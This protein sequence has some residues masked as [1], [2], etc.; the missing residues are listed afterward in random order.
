MIVLLLIGKRAVG[1]TTIAAKLEK[2]CGFKHIEMSI[3]L[4]RMRVEYKM[5]NLR[6]RLFVEYLRKNNKNTLAIENLFNQINHEKKV[7]ITGV[8][9]IEEL[10]F[11]KSNYKIDKLISINLKL[12]IFQR[13]HR[14]II[15]EKRNSIIEFLIEEF[16]TIKWG[17]YKI[18]KNC[19][20]NLKNSSLSDSIKKIKSIILCQ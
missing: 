11:L 13:L 19:D 16:Y 7:V 10:L 2:E 5:E 12:N 6:L 4:K 17:N 15:R 14:A 8:R 20:I 18:S 9:H 1:K 3:F